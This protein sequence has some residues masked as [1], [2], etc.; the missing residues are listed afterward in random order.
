MYDDRS[1]FCICSYGLYVRLDVFTELPSW[2]LLMVVRVNIWVTNSDDNRGHSAEF[3]PIFMIVLKH[4]DGPTSMSKRN[5]SP[6]TTW[7]NERVQERVLQDV[8]RWC[9]EVVKH[10]SETKSLMSGKANACTLKK[11]SN[12]SPVMLKCSYNHYHDKSVKSEL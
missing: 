3:F 4:S 10:V 9:T 11:C 1:I 6:L 12:W 8:L 2:H 5:S 7:N